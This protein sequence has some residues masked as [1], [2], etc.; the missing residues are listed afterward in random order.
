MVGN[1]TTDNVKAASLREGGSLFPPTEMRLSKRLSI[2][3]NIRLRSHWIG[4]LAR[5]LF[6]V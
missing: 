6:R 2:M 3:N 5:W 1:G 4:Y